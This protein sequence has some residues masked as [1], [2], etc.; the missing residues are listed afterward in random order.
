M[1]HVFINTM[2]N[3]K[4]KNLSGFDQIPIWP[5]DVNEKVMLVP[6]KTNL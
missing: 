4:K 6:H 5:F 1:A 2:W 3:L